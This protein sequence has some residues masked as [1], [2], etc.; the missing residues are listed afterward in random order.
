M[1]IMG[2]FF[3]FVMCFMPGSGTSYDPD[4]LFREL[5]PTERDILAHRLDKMIAYQSH[6]NWGS[7]Y[8]L[9]S[10]FDRNGMTKAQYIKYRLEISDDVHPT[11]MEFYPQHF[12]KLMDDHYVINGCGKYRQFGEI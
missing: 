11:L 4:T 3:C 5:A 12:T 6:A 7:V 1:R 8:D 9:L 2:A 10:I